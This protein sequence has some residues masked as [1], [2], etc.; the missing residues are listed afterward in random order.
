V[1]LPLIPDL[2]DDAKVEAAYA[3]VQEMIAKGEAQLVANLVGH[4]KDEGRIL[5][6][7]IEEMRYATEYNP[8]ELPENAPDDPKVLEHWPVTGITPT[9]F[10]TRNI[11]ATIELD[12]KVEQGG[13]WI[14]VNTVPQHVRFLRWAK[15]DAGKL[16]N[17][18]RLVIEQPIFHTSKIVSSFML[19]NGL[20]ALVS[21]H[22]VPDAADSME[23][24]LIKVQA[25]PTR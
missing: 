21:V 22:K 6:E 12:A 15:I 4:S 11:G 7:S 14:S 24:F 18:E 9:A 20:H 2:L 8:P 23:F 1:A 19:P 25:T 5:A 17:G 3:K 13:Q 16:A 10:E